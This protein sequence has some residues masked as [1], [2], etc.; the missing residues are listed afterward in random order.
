MNLVFHKNDKTRGSEKLTVQKSGKLGVSSAGSKLIKANEN[1]YC[2]FATDSETGDKYIV[3]TVVKD[4]FTYK[5]SKAGQYHYINCK[6]LLKEW[7]DDYTDSNI[8]IIYDLSKVEEKVFKLKRRVIK[9][10][11]IK[12]EPVKEADW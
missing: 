7:K 1:S 8:T 11:D 12:K 3:M 5:L 6:S 4:E 10:N 2:K 9:K